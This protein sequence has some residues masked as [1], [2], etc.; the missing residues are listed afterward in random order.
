MLPSKLQAGLTRAN[1]I[2]RHTIRPR[3]RQLVAGLR[4]AVARLLLLEPASQV[5]EPFLQAHV[6][7]VAQHLARQRDIGEAVADVAHPVLAGDFRPH[8]LLAQAA[9]H[10]LRHGADGVPASAAHVED[11]A[12]RL[13]RFERQPAGAR[14]VVDADE[15]P[16]LQSV[17]V[18]H[19][20]LAVEQPRGEDRQTPV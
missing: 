8:V 16:L 20:R 17:L 15:I 18:K 5:H 7:P 6:R 1:F 11:A 10:L 19:R 12:R 14:H 13:R 3:A 9:R 2:R 4:H